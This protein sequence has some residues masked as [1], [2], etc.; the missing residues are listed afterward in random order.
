MP[1]QVLRHMDQH[2]ILDR[3]QRSLVPGPELGPESDVPQNSANRSLQASVSA[4]I[5]AANA[6]AAAPSGS[7]LGFPGDDGGRSLAEMAQSD[8]NATLQLLAE[9]AQYITEAS[10]AAIALRRDTHNDMLCR[11]SAGS[12]A[13]ELGTLLSTEFGLSGESVRTRL[14]LR[15]DNAESDPRVNREGCRQLGIASVVVLPIVSD[16][17][18]L[19]VFELFSG[20][21]SA[22]EERDLSALQRLG[23]MVE[24]AVRLARAADRAIPAEDPRQEAEPEIEVVTDI[25][26]LPSLTVQDTLPPPSPVSAAETPVAPPKPKPSPQKRLLW[27]AAFQNTSAGAKPPAPDRSHVPPVLRNL[28]KCQACGFPVSEGRSLCVDCEEKQW[29]GQVGVPNRK[30][31]V[32]SAPAVVAA[33]ATSEIE[34]IDRT[35]LPAPTASEP[36][37]VPNTGSTNVGSTTPAEPPP[38]A[39]LSSESGSSI[40]APLP[41]DDLSTPLATP[42][43]PGA[44]EPSENVSTFSFLG[45]GNEAPESWLSANKYII[46]AL[47]LTA[48]SIAAVVLLR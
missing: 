21:V 10:G 46:G 5:A 6:A 44:A 29:R 26:S 30:M 22:F 25:S 8:L 39:V 7:A 19:G 34:T 23:E 43:L 15:C 40:P 18:V 35:A 38:L 28:H 20:K 4:A 37:A 24:T 27:S 45:S 11:A 17:Q 32:P 36:V 14:P 47:L 12:N 2:S 41:A 16:D 48:A 3:D 13:P 42:P 1:V 33:K 9:R 31:T